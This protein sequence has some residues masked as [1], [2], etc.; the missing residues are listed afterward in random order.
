MTVDVE[1]YFQV[2]AFSNQVRLE[3]WPSYP[4]RI[5]RNMDR[6]LALFDEQGIKATFF[7]LGWVAER[8]P[9]IMRRIA[10]E[11][12]ELASHGYQHIKVHEQTPEAFRADVRKTKRLLEDLSGLGIK[13]YRAASFSIGEKT[14]WAAEILAEE[15]HSYSSSI[16]PIRHDH[17]GDSQAP[18]F[19]FQ[20]S[21]D[22]GLVEIPITTL[23]LFSRHLPCAGGG[24]FRLLPYSYVRWA[25]QRVNRQEGQ[26]CIFYFHPWEVDP[27]Q[28]RFEG[29]PLKT[30][31]R[32]Y[33]NLNRMEGR[34]RTI[35][36]DFAW[37]RVDRVYLEGANGQP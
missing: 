13:G 4:C 5:E 10:E 18:R 1:D 26:P 22:H 21:G 15:G 27:E 8:Y 29:V 25:L 30:R 37:D 16:H 9:Q 33:T 35:L 11:G 14:P 28:P 2:W 19:P 31:L 7:T 3:D 20:P 17:Y 6:V 24:Y 12:H 32:H 23:N 34:L 36:K